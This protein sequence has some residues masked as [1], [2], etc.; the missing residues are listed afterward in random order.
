MRYFDDSGHDLYFGPTVVERANRNAF[1]FLVDLAPGTMARAI[2]A[3]GNSDFVPVG[4]FGERNVN[5]QLTMYDTF[6]YRTWP[7]RA[8]EEPT[9][10]EELPRP[11][12]A[13]SSGSATGTRPRTSARGG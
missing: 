5:D 11:T 7:F 4:V 10:V 1:D 9:V 8:W 12:R 2:L 3:P 13:I 6:A